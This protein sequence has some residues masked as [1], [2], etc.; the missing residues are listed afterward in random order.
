MG[1]TAH[2]PNFNSLYIIGTGVVSHS[3]INLL[4]IKVGYTGINANK[5]EKGNE[6][7]IINVVLNN[8]FNFKVNDVV[9][10][11]SHPKIREAALSLQRILILRDIKCIIWSPNDISSNIEEYIIDKVVRKD[12]KI[13]RTLV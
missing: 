2:K 8:F 4:A 12:L 3:N 5:I 11:E 10:I 9:V 13:Q 1:N 7:E 6:W